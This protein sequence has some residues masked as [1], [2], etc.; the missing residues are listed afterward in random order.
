MVAKTVQLVMTLSDHTENSSRG[1][2]Q[3]LQPAV[4]GIGTAAP[5]RS[6][7]QAQEVVLDPCCE[8]YAKPSP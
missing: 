6:A 2:I 8:P 5:V 3:L 1:Y 7:I 4:S